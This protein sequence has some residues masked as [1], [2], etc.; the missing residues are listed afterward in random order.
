MDLLD[1]SFV[2]SFGIQDLKALLVLQV[3]LAKPLD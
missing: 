1:Q 3:P 2:R